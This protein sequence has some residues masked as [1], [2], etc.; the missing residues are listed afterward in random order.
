MQR[1]PGEL[2]DENFMFHTTTCP[3]SD[4]IQIEAAFE[5]SA[6]VSLM[7][8]DTSKV[9]NRMPELGVT[10]VWRCHTYV[11]QNSSEFASMYG[12]G[13]MEKEVEEILMA[14]VNQMDELPDSGVGTQDSQNIRF[15]CKEIYE[16]QE[17]VCQKAEETGFIAKIKE[18]L[19]TYHK[20]YHP[21]NPW[22]RIEK[23]ASHIFSVIG[24]DG[25]AL[26]KKL[27]EKVIDILPAGI[28]NLKS[29]FSRLFERSAEVLALYSSF[30]S[31]LLLGGLLKSLGLSFITK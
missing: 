21:E 3:D 22:R 27:G 23:I 31:L 11:C 24:S 1:K 12:E 16:N 5:S 15:I 13:C 6:Y 30:H 26:Y 19:K 14:A 28:A 10:S 9:Q 8:S 18:I 25:G 29:N 7:M 20:D 17:T 4:I 2:E